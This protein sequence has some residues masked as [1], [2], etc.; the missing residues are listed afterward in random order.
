[1]TNE[2]VF[3]ISNHLEAR[4]FISEML[5]AACPCQVVINQTKKYVFTTEREKLY[6]L[7]ALEAILNIAPI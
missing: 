6:F 4:E 3:T 5:D 7:A 1:M 2:Y